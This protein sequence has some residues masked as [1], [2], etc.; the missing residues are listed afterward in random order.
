[1]TADLII[2]SPS[3]RRVSRGRIVV[4][5]S[6][7][8]NLLGKPTLTWGVP[9]LTQSAVPAVGDRTAVRQRPAQSTAALRVS[10]TL[11]TRKGSITHTHTHVMKFLHKTLCVVPRA[12][13][14]DQDTVVISKTEA[15]QNGYTS[16]DRYC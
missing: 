10:A 6:T 1:M 11:D 7:A 4:T 16:E 2:L 13:K 3:Y 15:P 5:C 12:A 9:T 8:L 14:S